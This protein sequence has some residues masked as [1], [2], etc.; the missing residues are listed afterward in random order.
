MEVLR[1]EIGPKVSAV[2][3]NRSVFHQPVSENNSLAGQ[4]VGP[5]EQD[6]SFSVFY[7]LRNR[8]LI[9]IGVVR[10]DPP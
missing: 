6:R 2:T 10:K 7:D 1:R 8:R 3:K 4:N 5:R 9:G